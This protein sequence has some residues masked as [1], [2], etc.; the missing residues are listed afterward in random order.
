MNKCWLYVWQ[1]C[2]YVTFNQAWL[3]KIN[4]NIYEVNFNTIH[5]DI[6]LCIIFNHLENPN[7]LIIRA[8]KTTL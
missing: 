3:G 1:R 6:N 2:Q 4:V 7:S 8:K 5:S